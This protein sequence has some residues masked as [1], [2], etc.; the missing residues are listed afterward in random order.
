MQK[1]QTKKMLYPLT[2]NEENLQVIKEKLEEDESQFNLEDLPR[3]V[4][5]PDQSM[6]DSEYIRVER[7]DTLSRS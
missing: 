6:K 7:N 2:D 3:E 5:Y 4:L 1:N